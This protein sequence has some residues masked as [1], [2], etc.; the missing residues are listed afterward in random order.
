MPGSA[1]TPG[2]MGTRAIASIRVAF[3][4]ADGVGSRVYRGSNFG[5]LTI[6]LTAPAKLSCVER[7][8]SR[9]GYATEQMCE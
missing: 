6:W 3:H 4:T 1:T 5:S 2:H 7:S 9:I 8:A